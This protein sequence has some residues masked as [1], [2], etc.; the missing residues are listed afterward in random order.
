MQKQIET[1]L[2][3]SPEVTDGGFRQVKLTVVYHSV[4]MHIRPLGRS[5]AIQFESGRCRAGHSLPKAYC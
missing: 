1:L 3:L 5:P 4:C 2:A